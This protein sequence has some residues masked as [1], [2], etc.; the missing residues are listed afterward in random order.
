MARHL[1]FQIIDAISRPPRSEGMNGSR[2]RHRGTIAPFDSALGIWADSISSD[3]KQPRT[4][5]CYRYF[6]AVSSRSSDRFAYLAFPNFADA[7]DAY[8]F[9][10]YHKERGK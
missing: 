10:L 1:E 6:R 7:K 9:F 8:A 2:V 3:D 4:D 5:N